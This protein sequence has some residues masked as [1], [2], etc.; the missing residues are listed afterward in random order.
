MKEQFSIKLLERLR[1]DSLVAQNVRSL[2]LFR[3][4]VSNR[5][6]LNRTPALEIDKETHFR[7]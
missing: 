1:P 6:P 7:H 4:L 3:T 2:T 5:H